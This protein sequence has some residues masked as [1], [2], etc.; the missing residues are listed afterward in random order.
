MNEVAIRLGDMK[1]SCTAGFFSAIWKP[2]PQERRCAACGKLMAVH[3]G[4]GPDSGM[5]W[6][7]VKNGNKARLTLKPLKSEA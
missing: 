2:V 5:C 7:C 6:H 3:R 1:T 4:Y